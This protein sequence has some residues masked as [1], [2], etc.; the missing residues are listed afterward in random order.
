MPSSDS[1][2]STLT[3]YSF[4]T[5]ESS[6]DQPLGHAAVLSEDDQTGR[7]D[8]QPPGRG[9]S[10]QVAGPELGP[11]RILRPPVLRPDQ[12]HRRRV[13]VLGL[14]GD[15]ADRLVGARRSPARPGAV[16]RPDRCR[17]AR[18]RKRAC[19]VSTTTPSTRT[20]PLTIQSSASRREHRPSS[21]MRLDRRGS[22]LP[23]FCGARG[24]GARTGRVGVGW[25]SSRRLRSVV[26]ALPCSC[27][28]AACARGGRAPAGVSPTVAAGLPRRREPVFAGIGASVRVGEAVGSGTAGATNEAAVFDGG[29]CPA[30]CRA[31]PATRATSA[32]WAR[33]SDRPVW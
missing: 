30:A 4:S 24:C 2:P 10:A 5:S 31:P 15:I 25:A 6:P 32:P 16:S 23:T 27:L 18:C 29:R 3:R 28:P 8:V 11:R 21:P 12:R 20:Q 33:R 14:A 9:E 7:V 19:S 17:C 22:S 1:V 26:R 13:A